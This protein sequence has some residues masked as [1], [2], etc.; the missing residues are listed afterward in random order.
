[1]EGKKIAGFIALILSLL[2]STPMWLF[3]LYEILKAVSPDRLVWAI[4]WTYVPIQILI[5][6]VS[7]ISG[8]LSDD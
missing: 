7:A 2:I 1:M 8:I 3:M 4:Y 6:I 5:V